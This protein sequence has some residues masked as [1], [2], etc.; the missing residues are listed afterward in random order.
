V[1]NCSD[2][3]AGAVD[4]GVVGELV[5]IEEGEDIRVHVDGQLNKT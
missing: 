5:A 2:F 3:A 4:L 1:V